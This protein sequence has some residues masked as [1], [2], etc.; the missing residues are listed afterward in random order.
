LYLSVFRI[1]S[2]LIGVIIVGEALALVV[3]IYV[4]SRDRDPWI[5]GKNDLMIYLD[6][7][8]GAI[9]IYIAVSGRADTTA[10]IGFWGAVH[11]ALAAHAYR[12]WEYLAKL[13]NAFCSNVPLFVMNNVKLLGLALVCVFG[14]TT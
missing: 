1:V 9:L 14:V 3:G 2:I 7:F 11:L 8:S 10:V 12:E 6:I 4:L 13:A 5:S